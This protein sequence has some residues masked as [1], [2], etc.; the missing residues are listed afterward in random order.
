M[1]QGIYLLD[2]IVGFFI[3]CFVGYYAFK[4]GAGITKD[5]YEKYHKRI[6]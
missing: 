2:F 1:N 4:I 3:W 5:F 6:R